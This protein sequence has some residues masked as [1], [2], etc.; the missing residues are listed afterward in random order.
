LWRNGAGAETRERRKE[1][2][3]M[4]LANLRYLPNLRKRWAP[5]LCGV[6]LVGLTL[7]GCGSSTPSNE[8]LMGV[9][10]FQTSSVTIKA[11]QA[12]DFV[13][14]TTGGVHIICVGEALQC[15]QQPGAPAELSTGQGITFNP[16][17]HRSIVF[18][19]PGTYNVICI[20]HPAMAVT[21]IVTA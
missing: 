21:I 5:L 13:N 9:A 2:Y 10:T 1:A 4:G 3:F 6:L 19:N 7:A 20:V 17:D 16:D 12:V 11:G 14:P 15:G 18:P 8:V